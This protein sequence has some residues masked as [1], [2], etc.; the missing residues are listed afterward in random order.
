MTENAAKTLGVVGLGLIGGSFARAGKAAGLRVIGADICAKT[1]QMALD[2]GAVDEVSADA[3]A[4]GAADEILIAVP[5]GATGSVFA[6][7]RGALRPAATVFDGGSC[8]RAPVREA[9]KYLGEKAGRFVPSHPI[10]GGEDS[11]FQA[12]SARLFS[13]KW[14]VLCPADSD[15]DAAA[16]AENAWR[17][18]GAKTAI[19][20]AEA[21]DEIF[22]AVSH[23]PH[24]LSFAL[25]DSIRARPNYEE[26]LRFAAG[27][28]RDFTRIAASHPAMWRDICLQNSDKILDSLAYFRRAADDIETAV[29]NGDGAALE[30]KFAAARELRRA[31]VKTLEE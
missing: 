12:S 3:A 8:K 1:R 2:A 15:A 9:A 5:V 29:K 22:S 28:F 6:A 4:A 18:A 11:G 16:A 30:E 14:A 25:V 17:R 27:G 10:A 23:L 7:L 24:L 31:W 13:G 21:H 26:L 19:L 20:S